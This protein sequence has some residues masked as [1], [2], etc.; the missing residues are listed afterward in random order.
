MALEI[1]RVVCPGCGAIA[2]AAHFKEHPECAR[3]VFSLSQMCRVAKRVNG[4]GGRPAKL[5]ACAK[6]GKIITG[7]RE[8]RKHK[9]APATVATERE[10]KQCR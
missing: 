6:C 8:L 5:A 9:C 10:E 4:R 3:R 2:S 1:E 7:T